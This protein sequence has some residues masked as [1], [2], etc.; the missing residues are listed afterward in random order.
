MDRAELKALEQ[1]LAEM[2]IAP[3]PSPWRKVTISAVGGLLAVGFGPGSDLLLVVSSQGRGVLDC[4]SVARVARNRTNALDELDEQQLVAFGIGPLDGVLVSMAGLPGGGLPTGSGDGWSVEVETLRWPER[5][6]FLVEPW[7]S[8][9]QLPPRATK[10]ATDGACT[11]R[12]AGFSPTGQ[13]LVVATS[14]DV[15]IWARTPGETA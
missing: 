10:I 1:I 4:R 14:C 8:L 13:S 6:I 12:A 7:Q 5:Y 9:Y 11:F 2:P 3:A 15:S